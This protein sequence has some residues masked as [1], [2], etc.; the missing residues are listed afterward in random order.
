QKAAAKAALIYTCTVCRLSFA[1]FFVRHK[2]Q[3]LRPSSS[4]L[5]AS[6]LRLHFLQN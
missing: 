3:T 4:T 6:I 2:C 5:R 1:Q